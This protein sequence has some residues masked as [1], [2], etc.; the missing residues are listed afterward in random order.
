MARLEILIGTYTDSY[1]DTQYTTQAVT[2]RVGDW[3]YDYSLNAKFI[4]LKNTGSASIAAGEIAVATTTMPATYTCKQGTGGAL[5]EPF[6]GSRL[7]T[8]NSTTPTSVAQN[9]YGWFQIS[10]NATV[11][12]DS[13]GTTAGK[14]VVSS[15]ATAGKVEVVSNTFAD[16]M[17]SATVFAIAQATASSG[18]AA[19]NIIGNVWGL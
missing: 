14:G 12:A 18:T 1:T 2:P 16:T 8:Y 15:N 19:V 4:F 11:L 9:E 17:N 7:Y 13:T 3:F 10:G 5:Q 6:A